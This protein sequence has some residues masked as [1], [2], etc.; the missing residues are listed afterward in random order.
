MSPSQGPVVICLLQFVT[1]RSFPSTAL[2]LIMRLRTIKCS[3]GRRECG[4]KGE[5]Q[6]DILVL[7][8]NLDLLRHI[9]LNL[10]CLFQHMV[11]TKLL[12]TKF[13][14]GLQHTDHGFSLLLC[15]REGCFSTLRAYSSH[16]KVNV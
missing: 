10:T 14:G 5:L 9:F 11:T 6:D 13:T 3:E 15:L 8:S 4:V 1:K 12:L 7:P 16:I 2:H